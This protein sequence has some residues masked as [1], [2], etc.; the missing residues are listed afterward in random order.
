MEERFT[1]EF[2]TWHHKTFVG[3][4]VD[5]VFGMD[6]KSGKVWTELARQIFC[7]QGENY[8]VIEHFENGE[9]YL[10]GYPGRISITHTSHLFA[11]A[12]LPKTPEVNLNGFNPRAAMGIDAE[13]LDRTQVLKVRNKFLSKEEQELIPED[14]VK[15]NILA[16]TSKEA[17]YKA[18]L[19][20]GL[21]FSQDILI[22][23]LP[24]LQKD[25][26]KG[27]EQNIGEAII[28]F[29]VTSN[30]EN[31]EMKIFS[32]E[33]YGCCVTL[34]FSPKCAKFGK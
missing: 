14:D 26:V 5:E 7:E 31:Q 23:K 3:I 29:P 33:S 6:S 9:P 13:P 12:M 24:E 30:I 2:V 21:D 4:K 15:S 11:V 32:Y 34:A 22:K 10:E 28:K 27:V 1:D 8:R 25:P 16:W 18:A 19:I 20:P 17:L